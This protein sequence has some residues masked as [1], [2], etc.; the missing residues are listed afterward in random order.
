MV[1]VLINY[2]TISLKI[3]ASVA[4]KNTLEFLYANQLSGFKELRLII[5]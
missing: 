5:H 3:K 2:K 1:S 4:L